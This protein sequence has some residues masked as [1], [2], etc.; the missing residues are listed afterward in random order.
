M[1]PTSYG[2]SGRF[3]PHELADLHFEEAGTEV[4]RQHLVDEPP[5]PLG[6]AHLLKGVRFRVYR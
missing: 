6:V 5:H 2:L 4:G 3:P 1:A